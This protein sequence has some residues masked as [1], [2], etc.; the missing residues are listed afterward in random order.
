MTVHFIGAGPG[1]PELITVRGRRLIEA[2]PVVLYAGS[3]VPRE[4]IACAP[5]G[6]R[7]LDTAPMTLDEIVDEMRAAHADGKDVARVHSGD[8]SLYGAIGEQMRRLAA[9]GIPYDVTP[10]VPAYA[11][12]AAALER[13]LTPPRGEPDRDPHPHEHPELADAGQGGAGRP[14]PIRRDPR[15]PPLDPKHRGGVRDPRP[16]LR[17]GLP[18]RGGVPRLVARRTH[19]HRHPRRPRGEGAPPPIPPHRPHPRRPGARGR[20]LRRQRPLRRRPPPPP[21]PPEEEAPQRAHPRSG[22]GAAHSESA[23]LSGP[24]ASS[25]QEIHS[26]VRFSKRVQGTRL[27]PREMLAFLLVHRAGA[28]NGHSWPRTCLVGPRRSLAGTIPPAT[29]VASP[30]VASTT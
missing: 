6:A 9:L 1:D 15:H 14:R 5:E 18:S 16:P 25:S 12:A 23:S 17:R 13:E 2:C 24:D 28:S 29:C 27:L 11:A 19:R 22:T 4:V 30:P 21:P 3:L 26:Q 10:G 7:V 8:P 20:D